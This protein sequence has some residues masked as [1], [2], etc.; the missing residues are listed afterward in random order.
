MNEVLERYGG[1]VCSG[2]QNLADRTSRP[3]LLGAL[4]DA[5][6][7]ARQPPIGGFAKFIGW[8]R[9]AQLR[10]RLATVQAN[11]KKRFGFPNLFQIFP[12]FLK[13]VQSRSFEYSIKIRRLNEKLARDERAGARLRHRPALEPS[14]A[15]TPGFLPTD[16]RQA[17]LSKICRRFCP[18]Y[19]SRPSLEALAS[20]NICGVRRRSEPFVENILKRRIRPYF[21]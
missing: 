15:Q 11:P 12:N 3:S 10:H 19:F 2:A 20:V 9:D 7:P 21:V 8:S 1:A 13:F 14:P 18:I 17:I 6:S 5:R 4:I 16:W